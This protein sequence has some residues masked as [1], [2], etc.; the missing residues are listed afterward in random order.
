MSKDSP[1]CLLLTFR[2]HIWISATLYRWGHPDYRSFPLQVNGGNFE[3]STILLIHNRSLCFFQSCVVLR[4]SY[5]GMHNFR[6]V[7]SLTR[8]RTGGRISPPSGFSQIAKKT[9]ARH[10][11]SANNLTHFQKKTMTRWHQRSRLQVT[12]SDLTSSCVFEVWHRAKGTPVIRTL[13][14]LQCTVR[15]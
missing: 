7:I 15:T 9:V 5:W 2:V 3:T 4:G 13:W 8:A 14:N 10:N 1:I 12:L 6:S 11:C